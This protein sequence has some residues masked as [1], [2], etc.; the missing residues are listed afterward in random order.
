[1]SVQFLGDIS[2]R[3]AF[4]QFPEKMAS[5]FLSPLYGTVV[6]LTSRRL[7]SLGSTTGH[8][9]WEIPEPRG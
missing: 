9:L 3:K 8:V 4:N 1:M 2:D 5:H 6:V 7:Q